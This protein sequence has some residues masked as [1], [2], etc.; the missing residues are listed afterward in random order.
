MELY[1]AYG[2][3]LYYEQMKKRC[4]SASFKTLAYYPNF[5]LDFTRES[6]KGGW[7]AD[8][9]FS[10]NSSVWGV[11]YALTS[12]D[13]LSLDKSEVIHW[14][15]GY[16]RQKI[17]VFDSCGEEYVAW[18]YFVKIKKGSGPPRLSYM[19]KILSGAWRYSLPESYVD[20]LKSIKTMEV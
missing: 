4:P 15:Y 16:L 18:T 2:S 3:N 17:V 10:P 6:T 8:M 11:V 19:N 12:E 20:F 5:K 9:V 14:L 7:V 1:F 13:L